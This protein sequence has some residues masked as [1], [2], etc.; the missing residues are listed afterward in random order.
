MKGK[1]WRGKKKTLPYSPSFWRPP[2]WMVP[3]HLKKVKARG[4]AGDV[5]AKMRFMESLGAI[6][7]IDS[8]RKRAGMKEFHSSMKRL[9]K[10]LEDPALRTVHFIR[11]EDSEGRG[12]IPIEEIEA[13]LAKVEKAFSAL[14]KK[15]SVEKKAELY[16]RVERMRI[17]FGSDFKIVVGGEKRGA[18]LLVGSLIANM[19]EAAMHLLLKD[20]KY[21]AFAERA[22]K[23]VG[24]NLKK[25]YMERADMKALEKELEPSHWKRL[26]VSGGAKF[27]V[28]EGKARVTMSFLNPEKA[29]W[30]NAVL[31]RPLM[32]K[33]ADFYFHSHPAT[34][35]FSM[36]GKS[37]RWNL[38]DATARDLG[39]PFILFDG[40]ALSLLHNGKT[41][42][43]KIKG[44]KI[45]GL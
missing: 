1:K 17:A 28:K 23:R 44:K 36:G 8:S 32:E 21:R 14:A 24:R 13:N 43:I 11:L 22:R 42:Y 3:E 18:T 20:K 10:Y 9:R 19:R 37:G 31:I 25:L 35:G 45:R 7:L 38:D 4:K 2:K 16:D 27:E 30:D 5:E 33:E 15:K 41:S 12:R 34:S 26:E 39:L 40:R 29:Y 6:K